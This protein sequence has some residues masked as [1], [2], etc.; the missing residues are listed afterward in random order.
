LNSAIRFGEYRERGDY[1][2]KVDPTWSYYPIYIRK[3]AWIE[4]FIREKA[5]K[6]WL[7]LD[8]G[9]GEGVLVEEFAREGYRI[10]GIDLNYASLFVHR[11][12]LCHLPY[13]TAAFD[14]L[15]CL[16]VI[17]HLALLSHHA[18]LQ[19]MARILKPAGRAV[20]SVPNLA[21][22]DSRLRFLLRGQLVRTS[23]VEKHPGDRPIGEY[24][25]M[26]SHAGFRVDQRIGIKMTLPKRVM[27]WLRHKL[28]QRIIYWSDAPAS[29]C[30][31]NIIVCQREDR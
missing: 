11:G 3:M 16:D 20:F 10:F 14:L 2:K 13:A 5:T 6:D 24:L 4:R 9:C 25:A 31:L 8:V 28:S 22:L 30:F 19:E 15:L 21:H 1:H 26:M 29:L 18:A 7:I 12:D 23:S 17:E 27:F